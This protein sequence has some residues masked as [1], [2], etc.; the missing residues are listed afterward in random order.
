MIEEL[1]AAKYIKIGGVVYGETFDRYE[2]VFKNDKVPHELKARA[3]KRSLADG[4]CWLYTLCA[5]ETLIAH[6]KADPYGEMRI[7][8]NIFAD[9]RVHCTTEFLL[10]EEEAKAVRNKLAQSKTIEKD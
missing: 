3:E 4:T 6:L 1:K 9:S 2:I 8:L 10:T 7:A 5:D